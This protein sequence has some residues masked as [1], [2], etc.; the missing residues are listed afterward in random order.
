MTIFIDFFLLSSKHD[1]SIYGDICKNC[2]TK[3]EIEINIGSWE[4]YD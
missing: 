3:N 4:N 2:Y 1:Y